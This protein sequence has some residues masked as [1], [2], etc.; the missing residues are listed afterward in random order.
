M[1][2]EQ[3]T[4]TDFLAQW[5]IGAI[6]VFE[7]AAQYHAAMDCVI[8]IKEDVAYRADRVDGYLTLLWHPREDRIV[9][10]KLKGF[11]WLYT[12]VRALRRPFPPGDSA[13]G[14][15]PLI[16][17]LE[18]ALTARLGQILAAD[19]ADREHLTGELASVEALY[20]QAKAALD[21]IDIEVDT[22]QIAAAA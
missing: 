20:D 13:V 14:F 8:Y 12:R 15:I 1:A 18:T 5:N 22:R 16:Q 4:L 7:P 11:C 6:G 2:T 10:V 9:G 17:V 3:L 21:P 19:D